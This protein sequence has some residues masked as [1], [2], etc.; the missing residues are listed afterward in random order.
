MLDPIS[1]HS[2]ILFSLMG[3]INIKNSSW[4]YRERFANIPAIETNPVVCVSHP[5]RTTYKCAPPQINIQDHFASHQMKLRSKILGASS[6][7]KAPSTENSTGGKLLVLIQQVYASARTK[8]ISPLIPMLHLVRKQS[9][10][11]K[12]GTNNFTTAPRILHTF[13]KQKF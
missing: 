4:H 7:L 1:R 6:M 9:H 13:L 5:R 8:M 10:D 2:E 3:T 11:L 12:T